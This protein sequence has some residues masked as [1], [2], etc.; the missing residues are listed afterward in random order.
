MAVVAQGGIQGELQ[1]RVQAGRVA[2]GMVEA[3]AASQNHRAE[4]RIP[5]AVVAVFGMELR[6]QGTVT[7]AV[8][9]S[10]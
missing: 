1:G 6:H 10:S 2:A 4:H 5:A 8:A 3:A 7:A 9:L